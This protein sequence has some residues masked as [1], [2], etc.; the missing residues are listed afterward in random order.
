MKRFLSF[1]PILALLICSCSSEYNKDRAADLARE[2][3]FKN[4]HNISEQNRAYITYTYPSI[5]VVPLTLASGMLPSLN[6]PITPKT[7]YSQFY[8]AWD[9]PDP[10]ITIMVYGV[11]YEDLRF[12]TPSRIIFEEPKDMIL[13]KHIE[14]KIK[15]SGPGRIIET[16]ELDITRGHS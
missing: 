16:K 1:F 15:P 12:W 9:L 4:I 3:L 13:S 14:Q 8:F 2:Y 7:I 11:G 10:S 6:N 5:V